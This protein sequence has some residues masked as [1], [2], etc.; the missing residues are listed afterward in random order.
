MALAPLAVEQD[1][2]HGFVTAF[3]K[4]WGETLKDG[5]KRRPPRRRKGRARVA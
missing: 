5:K 1:Q 3:L 2:V 4:H